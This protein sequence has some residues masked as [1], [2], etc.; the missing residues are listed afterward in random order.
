M[1]EP[2]SCSVSRFAIKILDLLSC[3]RV[4][5]LY[6]GRGWGT[7]KHNCLVSYLLGWRRHVS[8]T[9]GQLQVTKMYIEENYTEYDHSIGAYCKLKFMMYTYSTHILNFSLQY[10]PILWSYSVQFTICTYTMIILCIVYN[11]HLYYDHTVYSLQYAPIL[12]SYS[13]QFTICTN[14]MI[15]LCTVYNMRLYYDHTL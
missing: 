1:K 6:L 12:W 3:A 15:I 7:S 13:V 2:S 5:H 8:A 10:A 11:M 14:N 9:V 4:D